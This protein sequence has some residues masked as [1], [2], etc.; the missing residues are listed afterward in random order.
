MQSATLAIALALLVGSSGVASEV[1]AAV[2]HRQQFPEAEWGYHYYLTYSAAAEPEKLKAAAAF[3]VA[4]TSRQQIIERCTPEPVTETLAHIDLR[5]LQWSPKDVATVLQRYP[6]SASDLPLIIRADWLVVELTDA[7]ASDSYYRLLY[8]GDRIPQTRDEF[9]ASWKVVADKSLRFGRIVGRSGVSKSG[10][11][12]IET[13]AM[14]RGYAWGTRDAFQID[15]D[16][17]PLAHLTGDQAHDGEE[18][19]VG[20]PKISIVSGAR[21]ALQVYFLSDDAGKRVEKADPDLVEDSTRFRDR[22]AVRTAGSCIQCHEQGL[23]IPTEDQ[24]RALIQAGADVY[25]DKQAQEEIERFHLSD[26]KRDLTRANEDFTAAVGAVCGLPPAEAVSAFRA[27]V[28]GYDAPVSLEAAARELAVPPELL[29]AALVAE[30]ERGDLGVRLVALAHGQVIPRA[31]WQR[32]FLRV[33]AAADQLKN[34]RAEIVHPPDAGH[35]GDM[36]T[37]TLQSIRVAVEAGKTWRAAADGVGVSLQAAYRDAVRRWP[38]LGGRRPRLTER[39]QQ[40]LRVAIAKAPELSVRQLARR[41]GV[42][43]DTITRYRSLP[44]P[45]PEPAPVVVH[46]RGRLSE[47]LRSEICEAIEGATSGVSYRQLARQFGVSVDTISRF[48]AQLIEDQ[49]PADLQRF[50]RVPPYACPVCGYQ[51]QFRPCVICQAKQ[52]PTERSFT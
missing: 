4:S 7:S 1:E 49:M 16:T 14:A 50:L 20:V 31:T 6:Y 47:E 18:W 33:K 21:G 12:W 39:Q 27:V 43:L 9:L 5:N 44:A 46:R 22:A 26:I 40:G 41:F 42:S 30:S 2:A 15:P 45:A 23:N 52:F 25:A 19:I 3:V 28:T 32:E 34:R 17:D 13:R 37:N 29:R 38:H 24:L 48:A 35:L 36:E 10:I 11:R 51:V 8:G